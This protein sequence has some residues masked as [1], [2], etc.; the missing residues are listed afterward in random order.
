MVYGL[1]SQ[2]TVITSGEG[3]HRDIS[4]LVPV[5]FINTPGKGA[6]GMMKSDNITEYLHKKKLMHLHLKQCP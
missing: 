5:L 2:W 1:F 4:V 3:F 6:N